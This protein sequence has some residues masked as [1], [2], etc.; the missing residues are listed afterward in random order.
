MNEGIEDDHI[1]WDPN[2]VQ[3]NEAKYVK[4]E[5]GPHQS[6]RWKNAIACAYSARQRHR[7]LETEELQG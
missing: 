5:L 2:H 4:D 7:A 1:P 6:G 3:E